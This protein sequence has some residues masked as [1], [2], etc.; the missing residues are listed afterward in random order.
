M[1]FQNS[2]D[3]HQWLIEISYN[4]ATTLSICP[5]WGFIWKE[6]SFPYFLDEIVKQNFGL[7]LVQQTTYRLKWLGNKLKLPKAITTEEET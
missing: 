3:D 7:E 4:K 2:W 5:L 6:V 1:D